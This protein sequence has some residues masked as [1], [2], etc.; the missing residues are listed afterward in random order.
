[1]TRHFLW[2]L[3]SLLWRSTRLERRMA[4]KLWSERMAGLQATSGRI[5]SNPQLVM[6]ASIEHSRELVQL[7]CFQYSTSAISLPRLVPH[8]KTWSQCGILFN[9][10]RM[11][12][13]NKSTTIYPLP[14]S[15]FHPSTLYDLLSHV[16]AD[17]AVL[18]PSFVETAAKDPKFI[19]L[20][21]AKLTY[22]GFAGGPIS[23]AARK[24]MASNVNF[25][26]IY[27]CTENG[28]FPTIVPQGLWIQDRWNTIQLHPEAGVELQSVGDAGYELVVQRKAEE[29]ACSARLQPFFKAF[30]HINEWRT[31]DIF[32]ADDREAGLWTYISRIDG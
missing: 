11:S 1:M 14:D 2:L 13:A 31:K 19:A 22:V 30:P 25:F 27:A 18:P 4:Q 26:C 23:S 12:I 8:S 24:E 21:S 28:V 20:I 32:A 16:D 10:C 29:G 6:R 3:M 17:T 5:N 15:P 9:Y 7:A